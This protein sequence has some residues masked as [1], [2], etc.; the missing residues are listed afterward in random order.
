[1]GL[2]TRIT[3]ILSSY[4][5]EFLLLSESRQP[6]LFFDGKRFYIKGGPYDLQPFLKTPNAQK[7]M[8]H[9]II[10]I[11]GISHSDV[12]EDPSLLECDAVS[13]GG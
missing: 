12:T 8:H 6:I 7:A 3:I 1:M 9:N 5:E 2:E 11:H 4:V 10:F 13:F